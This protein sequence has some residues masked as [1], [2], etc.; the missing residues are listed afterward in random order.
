MTILHYAEGG[1]SAFAE[2]PP[3]LVSCYRQAA[4]RMEGTFRVM[5]EGL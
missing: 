5:G 1:N 4:A 3:R 2:L